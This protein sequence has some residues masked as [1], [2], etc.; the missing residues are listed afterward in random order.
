M[1]TKK[2]KTMKTSTK[3]F[4]KVMYSISLI[5]TIFLLSSCNNNDGKENEEKVSKVEAPALDIH[6]AVL[7]GDLKAVVQHIKA[8]SELNQGDPTMGST[9]LMIA[10]VFDRTEI[11]AALIEAGIDLDQTN[12]DGATALHSAAFLCRTE[13]VEMLVE[14]GADKTIRNNFGSTA[15][16]SVAGPFESIKFVY[17]QFSKD[18]GPLG[19]KLDYE[20]LEETRPVIAEMLK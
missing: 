2:Q 19:L 17:E 13:I 14:N 10:A 18:L 16:E 6:S 3:K 7:L 8:G 20:Q 4:M 11:A 1:K 15:Y 5:L 9:P 12:N